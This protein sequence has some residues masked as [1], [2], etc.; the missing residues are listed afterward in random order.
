MSPIVYYHVNISKKVNKRKD[1]NSKLL[2]C[3]KSHLDRAR[4]W[5]WTFKNCLDVTN[6]VIYMSKVTVDDND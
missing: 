6:P 3:Q 5:I 4:I 1:S 2:I